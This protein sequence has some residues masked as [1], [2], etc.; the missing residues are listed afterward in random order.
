MDALEEIMKISRRQ[1]VAASALGCAT[2]L[3]PGLAFAET[4]KMPMRPLGKTGEKVPILAFG[5]GSRYLMYQDADEA[6]AVLNQA[7]DLG[8]TYIDTSNDYGEHG[9]SE[10]RIGEVMKTRRKDVL[11]ATKINARKAD[12]AR[13]MIET[14]LKRLKTDHLDVLHI[15]SLGGADDLAAIEA[16]D[17]VL[18]ALY[19]ARDQRMTRFV[20]VT[21]H[22]DPHTLAQ[23]LERHDFDC[24]QMALNAGLTRMD[25]GTKTTAVPMP[26]GNFEAV[27]LPVATRKKLGVIA[28][29][30]FGQDW[31]QGK[32]PVEKLIYYSMS[33]PV[34]TAVIGMPKR[35]HVERNAEIAWNFAPLNE[36][37]MHRIS[38]SITNEHKA[39]M[40]QFFRNHIDA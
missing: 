7:I 40:E 6:I 20:G 33:L 35:E 1:F 4:K 26:Q 9:E 15:H 24:T 31:L 16:P 12:E 18:N 21:S 37:E 2:A 14:S 23:A 34:S 17:G 38:D 32:A 25:F 8:I 30:V 29:K 28:M 39:A 13:R 11:L 36:D 3:L 27:A 22:T 19:W 5:G 10:M